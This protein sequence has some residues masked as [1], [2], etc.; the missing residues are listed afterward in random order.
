MAD[1]VYLHVGP[2]KTGTTFVQQMLWRNQSRLA[3]A[4]IHLPLGTR[5]AHFLAA[6]DLLQKADWADEPDADRWT[7]PRFAEAAAEH[8]GRAVLSE[9]ML[10]DADDRCAE[11][12]LRFLAPAEVH[13]I[14]T[15]RDL[16]RQIPSA[17]QQSIKH[18]GSLTL[19]QF[20]QRIAGS[21]DPLKFWM[22]QDLLRVVRVWRS[23][24]PA[25]S[26]RLVT[27]P[28]P[29]EPANVLW[30]RFAE[31]AGIDID[32]DLVEDVP[33]Q[34][35]GPAEIEALRRFNSS[36]GE[37]L[38]Y[39][40]PYTEVVRR[41][42]ALDLAGGPPGTTPIPPDW[43]DWVTERSLRMVDQLA[44][45]GATVVGDLQ[46]LVPVFSDRSDDAYTER[47]ISGA[48]TRA[49]IASAVSYRWSLVR[50]EDLEQTPRNWLWTKWRRLRRRWRRLR[51]RWQ[52]LR[53]GL[54]STRT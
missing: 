36:L 23:H 46:D 43:R 25:G 24:L 16:A 54:L 34:S 29:G 38:P 27:V 53:R 12:A 15:A 22:R 9:E 47:D 49:L 33:N 35:L 1:R 28:P 39:P 31:A 51:R 20:L 11:H 18:R 19:D 45:A 32:V 42:V 10:A 44:D 2:P 48:T 17:W 40:H 52:W 3:D 21:G 37:R 8:A 5:K 13:V 4:G 6:A 41:R 30:T 26:V 50:I 7:W 14:I